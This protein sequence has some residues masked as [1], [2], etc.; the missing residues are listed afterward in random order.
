M[1][2]YDSKEIISLVNNYVPEQLAADDEIIDTI[3]DDI[4]YYGAYD[5]QRGT[6]KMAII[7]EYNNWVIKIPFNGIIENDGSFSPFPDDKNFDC[8]LLEL[9]V[10]EKMKQYNLDC[11][12]ANI[13]YIDTVNNIAIYV[14]E[15]IE[16]FGDQKTDDMLLIPEPFTKFYNWLL[17]KTIY[18]KSEFYENDKDFD[19]LFTLPYIWWKKAIISYGIKKVQDFILFILTFDADIIFIFH[20]LHCYNFG[21]RVIDNSPCICDYSGYSDKYDQYFLM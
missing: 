8:C 5:V 21:F 9:N 7:P 15:K 13:N 18:K 20:D 17:E 16:V 2:I 19:T 3:Y 12:F 6:F 1:L 11:F 10:L 14:Q 4:S